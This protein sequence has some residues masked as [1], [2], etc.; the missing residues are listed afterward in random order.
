MKY[1]FE[2]TM[3]IRLTSWHG[4]LLIAHPSV[5]STKTTDYIVVVASQYTA[6]LCVL[7]DPLP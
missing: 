5:N 7:K 4:F 3:G 2:D 6:A 1:E